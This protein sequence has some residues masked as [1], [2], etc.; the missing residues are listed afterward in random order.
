MT[1]QRRTEWT[2]TNLKDM[3]VG[4]LAE[5]RLGPRPV[6]ERRHTCPPANC[7]TRSSEAHASKN[8]S[9]VAEGV[10]EKLNDGYGFLRAPGR[11]LPARSGRYLRLAVA[12]PALRSAHRRHGTRGRS[13]CPSPASATSRWAG[14]SRSTAASR[15]TV[16]AAARLRPLTPLYPQERLRMEVAGRRDISGRVMDLMTPLGKGQRG[17]I[18]SPPRTGKTMLLQAIAQAMAANHPEVR[19]IVLLIDERPG[20]G[21]RH[22]AHGPGRGHLLHLRRA[23]DPPRPGGRDGDGR[24]PSGWS[25]PAGTWCCCS[26]RSPGWPG[27][28]TR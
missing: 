2:S 17:L 16:A 28:T 10:L 20:G 7:C 4:D 19:L 23:G 12:D 18:V 24:R 14:S 21:H 15:R 26:T 8:G 25:S 1:N 27:P 6:D 22:G 9:I 5:D 3:E 13:A 11:Q